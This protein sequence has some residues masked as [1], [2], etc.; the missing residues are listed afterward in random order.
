MKDRERPCSIKPQQTSS[1]N[2]LQ[3]SVEPTARS[4]RSISLTKR[5]RTGVHSIQFHGRYDKTTDMIIRLGSGCVRT[6]R[7][8]HM[9][10]PMF[11]TLNEVIERYGGQISKGILRNWRSMRV[12]PS[13]PKVGKAV[14]S[15]L[16]ELNQ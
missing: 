13:F 14:L 8:P 4:G 2:V 10:E 3:R 6:T 7:R 15:P 12:G 1:R 11:L 16:E 5:H 9:S